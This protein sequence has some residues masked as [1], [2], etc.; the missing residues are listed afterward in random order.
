MCLIFSIETRK[1]DN[2]IEVS[3]KA[4]FTIFTK[5]DGW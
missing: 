3:Q 4:I 5:G 2:D 1:P